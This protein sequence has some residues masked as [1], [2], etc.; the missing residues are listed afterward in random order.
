[1]VKQRPNNTTKGYH[2]TQAYK[3]KKQGEERQTSKSKK[4]K[5]KTVSIYELT[6]IGRNH[7]QVYYIRKQLIKQRLLQYTQTKRK[8]IYLSN[9][10]Q[11]I[12]SKRRERGNE[13]ANT[14]KYTL[15]QGFK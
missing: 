13:G 15:Y 10:K 2:T 5:T 12:G 8:T 7:T 4:A 3:R 9:D 1:M 14:R 6:T 11:E